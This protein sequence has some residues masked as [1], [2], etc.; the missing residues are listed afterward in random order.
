M[1][2]VL[3]GAPGSGKGTQGKQLSEK[4]HIPQ[5][6]TGDLLRAAVAAETPLGLQAKA[7]MDA[8]HLVSDDIVLGMIEERLAQPD[9]KD[10]F[11]LDG[12][13]RNIP[14]AEALD[15]LLTRIG[16]PL[17]VSLLMDVDVDLLMQRLTGRR[18][19]ESCSQVFNIYTSPSKIDGRC[20]S[21][22]G[23]LRHRADDREETISNRLKVYEAQTAPLVEYYR[24]R[25]KLRSVEA[26]GEIA[27]IFNG[28]CKLLDE[29]LEEEQQ[30]A[31]EVPAEVEAIAAAVTEKLSA[32]KGEKPMKKSVKRKAAAKKK[33]AAKKKSATKKKVVAK[34]K[35]ASKK[36]VAKKKVAKKKAAKKK[37]A[38]KKVAKRKAAPK[39]KAAKKKAA[40]KRK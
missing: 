8:G 39:R 2:I 31:K 27:D 12:F 5:I 15:T 23:N 32:A 14:Q 16:K 26:I 29:V 34:K 11:I 7:T 24:G 9:A 19:C 13:P 21:C 35:V 3:L 18:T 36:K 37:V 25:G 30:R 33:T 38:K 6:S 1:R 28:I 10:G 40:K 4:Y 22:G 20:D 17:Q